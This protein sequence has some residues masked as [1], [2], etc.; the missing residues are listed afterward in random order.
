MFLQS[1]CISMYTGMHI[2]AAI[3]QQLR[4]KRTEEFF[5][6]YKIIKF[7][8]N[9]NIYVFEWKIRCNLNQLNIRKSD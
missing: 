7:S 6:Y 9:L 4:N 8:D 3:K 5:R 2:V 1:L